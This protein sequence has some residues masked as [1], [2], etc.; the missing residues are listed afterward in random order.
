MIPNSKA[1]ARLRRQSQEYLDFVV[2]S[3]TAAPTLKRELQTV[4][5]HG[6]IRDHFKGPPN[7]GQLL[8]YIQNYQGP[9]ARSTVLTLW[10]FFEAYVKAL[11]AEIVDFHGGAAAFQSN[12]D[13]RAKSFVASS[14]AQIVAA[15]RKLQEPAKGAKKGSYQKHSKTLVEL[16]YRFPSELLAPFGVKILIQR[17]KPTGSKAYQIQELLRDALCFPLAAADVARIDAIREIRNDIAHGSRVAL[18]LKQALKI[19]KDLKDIAAKVDR[20]A[21]EHFFI[22]EAF[23]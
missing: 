11:L 23:T 13:R 21:T 1:Y 14:S 4:G 9:L 15:K 6:L 12:A 22:L 19:G 17:A 2:L 10:S 8:T 5:V 3:C 7:P 16:G 18:T 20:H